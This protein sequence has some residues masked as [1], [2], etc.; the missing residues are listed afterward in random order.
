MVTSAK[1]VNQDIYY[2]AKFLT[3]NNSS[4]IAIASQIQYVLVLNFG[5]QLIVDIDNV[6]YPSDVR[7]VKAQ[8]YI[9]IAY[10][11]VDGSGTPRLELYFNFDSQQNNTLLFTTKNF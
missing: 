3:P 6:T 2:K 5:K 9:V 1:M 7:F 4:V 11:K 8:R 10:E